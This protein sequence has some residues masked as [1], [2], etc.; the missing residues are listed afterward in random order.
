M[1]CESCHRFFRFSVRFN[2]S[3]PTDDNILF[4]DKSS[5]DKTF[6]VGKAVFHI[7]YTASKFSA[8]T[9]FDT[10]KMK[11]V[12]SVNT[13]WLALVITCCIVYKG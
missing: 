11:C 12:Q 9:V 8:A 6:L 10:H 13:I 4:G 5:V 2:V 7:V 1:G 3:I